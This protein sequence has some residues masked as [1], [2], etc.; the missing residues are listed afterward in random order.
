VA[1]ADQTVGDRQ[2]AIALTAV[3]CST[4]TDVP[5]DWQRLLELTRTS[6]E[7]VHGVVLL[8]LTTPNVFRQNAR[9]ETSAALR[10]GLAP[11]EALGEP[12]GRRAAP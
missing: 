5:A 10:D 7:D 9:S 6:P 11:S 8:P 4:R 1:F 3:R 12:P 2:K